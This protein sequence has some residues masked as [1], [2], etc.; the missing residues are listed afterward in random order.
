MSH[1]GVFYTDSFFDLSF[2]FDCTLAGQGDFRRI[3]QVA[4][5]AFLRAIYVCKIIAYHT[6]IWIT[7]AASGHA[8]KSVYN[9]FA[10]KKQKVKKNPWSKTPCASVIIRERFF[11]LRS[12][13]AGLQ[14]ELWCKA[15]PWGCEGKCEGRKFTLT[16]T[17]TT[18]TPINRAF[19][20]NCEG[21]RV[22]K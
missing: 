19:Q 11:D 20:A 16:L 14:D 3:L 17:L 6:T 7:A 18:E 5:L 22:R 8:C 13:A 10:S 9:P 12:V 4:A 2:D 15:Y 1:H 21:V